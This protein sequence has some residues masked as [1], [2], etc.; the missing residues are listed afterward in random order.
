MF[1]LLI[2]IVICVVASKATAQ[3][4]IQNGTF[5]SPGCFLE[6]PGCQI[7]GWENCS[8]GGWAVAAPSHPSEGAPFTSFDDTTHIILG[9]I[10]YCQQQLNCILQKGRTYKFQI[11]ASSFDNSPFPGPPG[12]MGIYSSTQ[13]CVLEELLYKS[14]ELAVGWMYSTIYITPEFKNYDYFL[15]K[16]ES[17]TSSYY[18]RLAL[19]AISH[20]YPHNGNAVHIQNIV[21]TTI[22]PGAC[23]QLQATADITTYDTVFW[24]KKYPVQDGFRTDT[25]RNT[26]T[27]NDC[28]ISSTTYIIALRD[29]VPDCAGYWWSYDTVKV[30]VNTGTGVAPLSHAEGLGLRL[31]P[32]P[33]TNTLTIQTADH[34]IQQ[35]SIYDINGK[36]LYTQQIPQTIIAKVELQGILQIQGMYVVEITFTSGLRQRIKFL[37]Q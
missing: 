19:D 34:P 1:R 8:D 36:M 32:N 25:I 5:N 18:N 22:Q 31:F 20:I 29:S 23:V 6:P 17:D 11:A 24:L 2:I 28:P 37:K 13:S 7:D 10:I 4:I 12:I 33:A 35:I 15:I 27:L 16:A 14:G 21:D 26:F 3:I 9:E 30:T